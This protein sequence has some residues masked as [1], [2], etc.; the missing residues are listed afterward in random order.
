VFWHYTGNDAPPKEAPY[1]SSSATCWACEFDLGAA[2]VLVRVDD[3][4]RPD[5]EPAYLAECRVCPETTAPA[6]EPVKY[7]DG[8]EWLRLDE[9][10]LPNHGCT[11][12][13]PLSVGARLAAIQEKFSNL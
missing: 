10:D 1:G 8:H 3:P 5:V 6:T 7:W 12:G 9:Y 13:Q 4:E 11:K 2:G